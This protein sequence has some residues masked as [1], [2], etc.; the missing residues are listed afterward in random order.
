MEVNMFRFFFDTERN[1]HARVFK[2]GD[3]KYVILDL[4]KEKP[5]HGYEI[6]R[7]LEERFHGFYSPSAGSVYPTLQLLEDMGYVSS[8]VADG[9]KVYSITEEGKKFLVEREETIEGIRGRVRDWWGPGADFPPPHSGVH[10]AWDW[11]GPGISEEFRDTFK[12]WRDVARSIGRRA[13]RMDREKINKIK[14]IIVQARRDIEKVI[15]EEK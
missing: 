7:A 14:A 10:A 1:P 11:W 2:K 3:I 6:I 13:R 12:E 15:G 4:L 9:K 8:T 5:R